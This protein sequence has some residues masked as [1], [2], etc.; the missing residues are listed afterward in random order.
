VAIAEFQVEHAIAERESRRFRRGRFRHQLTFDGAPLRTA[1]ALADAFDRAG[2]KR[3]LDG[4][5]ERV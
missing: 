2:Q 3:V 1:F 5:V 4:F